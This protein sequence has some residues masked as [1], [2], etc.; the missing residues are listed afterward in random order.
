MRKFMVVCSLTFLGILLL[1]GSILAQEPPP[2]EEKLQVSMWKGYPGE[3]YAFR[4]FAAVIDN[5]SLRIRTPNGR[6]L[7][8]TTPPYTFLDEAD[9]NLVYGSYEEFSQNFPE[10]KYKVRIRSEG[11]PPRRIKFHMTHDFPDMPVL[12][13]PTLGQTGVSLAP[14]IEWEGLS[15]IDG[16]ELSMEGGDFLLEIDLPPDATFYQFPSGLLKPDTQY[17]LHLIVSI[18]DVENGVE[19]INST[20]NLA[21][22]TTIN[23]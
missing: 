11:E 3:I 23:E 6:I 21:I 10:G 4:Y 22:F 2:W 19:K 14:L 12:I 13:Y 8:V 1:S 15:N 17:A 5:K 9:Q 18:R 7:R 20:S 16:L